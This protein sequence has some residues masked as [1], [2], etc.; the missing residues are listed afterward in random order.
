MKCEFNL[1]FKNNQFCPYVTSELYSNKTTCYSSKL[2]DI[3]IIYFKSKGYLFNH[4]AE[5]NIIKTS[6]TWDMSYNFYIKHN[7]HAVEWKLFSM[8]TK[9]KKL[10]RKFNR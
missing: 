1:V 5:K 8:I 4:I 7:M 9:N 6:N 3:V 10:M 2:L